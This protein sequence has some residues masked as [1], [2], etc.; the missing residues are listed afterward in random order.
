M[1]K[2]SIS[3]LLNDQL[4][5][6]RK[7]V[8][9]HEKALR[10]LKQREKNLRRVAR[11][12]GEKAVGVRG[13]ARTNRR[14]KAGKKARAKA[15]PLR[16]VRRTNWEATVKALPQT[17]TIEQLAQS[18]GARGKS[19]AYLHQIINRWKKAGVIKSAG[20]ATYAKG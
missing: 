14:A 19:R 12:L 6:V 1:V 8:S 10:A 13:K 7:Q 15:K 11:L 3:N 18:S 5:D 20:R 9:G 16:K 4:A 2:A 17:F